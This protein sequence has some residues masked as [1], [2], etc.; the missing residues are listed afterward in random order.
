MMFPCRLP[1]CL[2]HVSRGSILSDLSVWAKGA[3][4]LFSR[5]GTELLLDFFPFLVVTQEM[6]S[7]TIAALYT[8]LSSPFGLLSTWAW[9]TLALLWLLFIHYLDHLDG[10][11][12]RAPLDLR[13]CALF[14]FLIFKSF[15]SLFRLHLLWPYLPHDR[16][17]NAEPWKWQPPNRP[18]HGPH[19]FLK[20]RL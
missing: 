16:P 15:G 19:M 2:L 9:T 14:L 12:K 6:I 13:H 7:T 1:L 10:P 8:L 17:P 18:A 11:P 4:L 3:G 5:G 20:V